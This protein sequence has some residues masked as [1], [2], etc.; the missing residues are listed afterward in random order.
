MIL[1]VSQDWLLLKR[2]SAVWALYTLSCSHLSSITTITICTES[3]QYKITQTLTVL[4]QSY[5][6]WLEQTFLE[7]V[8]CLMNSAVSGVLHVNCWRDCHQQR[9]KHPIWGQVDKMGAIK[10]PTETG[11]GEFKAGLK[12]VRLGEL[13]KQMAP[14][15]LLSLIIL[16]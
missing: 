16:N 6:W 10:H 7:V 8:P 13:S 1:S 11:E 12:M 5:R 9:G 2:R 4:G 15:P 3:Q 14:C